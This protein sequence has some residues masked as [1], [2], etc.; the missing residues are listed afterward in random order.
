MEPR[1]HA[2]RR[3]PVV[4]DGQP[5]ETR[6]QEGWEV[7]LSY[8][9]EDRG[10]FLVDLSHRRKWDVQHGSLSTVRAWD[11]P[12]PASPGQCRLETGRLLTRRTQT[13]AAIWDL[14]GDGP[15]GVPEP[16]FTEVTDGLC[17]LAL[18]GHGAFGAMEQVSSLDLAPPG[19]RPPFLVQGPVLHV[20]AQAVI[21][22]GEGGAPAVLLAFPR[23]YGQ[24]VAEALLEA[25]RRL[26]LRPGGEDVFRK[27]LGA[28]ELE[29]GRR[30]GPE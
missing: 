6:L 20:P 12:F 26:G 1:Q 10:P 18:I 24:A 7:V 19:R 9:N 29:I 16:C 8:A 13:R 15:A 14:A 3:S 4:L 30:T 23:G 11:T 5:L 22:A 27:A 21:L 17:L 28:L 25:G 2:G